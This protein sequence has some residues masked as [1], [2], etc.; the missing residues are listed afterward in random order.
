MNDRRSVAAAARRSAGLACISG[1]LAASLFAQC[2]SGSPPTVV[3]VTTAVT[4][5]A[6]SCI[7]TSTSGT[8]I[9]SGSSTVIFQAGTT[10]Y[11]LPGFTAQA[12]T[13]GTAFIASIGP[14]ITTISL[15]SGTA[16]AT[17]L[18]ELSAKE[19]ASTGPF[20]WSANGIPAGLTLSPTGVLSGTTTATGTLTATFF[21][22]DLS[23]HSSLPQVLAIAVGV[24]QTT[25][26]L[27]SSPNPSSF[28]QN[29]ILTAAVSPAN[30]TGTVT[31]ED[32]ATT[33]GNGAVALS[34][35]TAVL[36]VSTLSAGSHSL[37]AFYSGDVND[38][39]SISVPLNIAISMASPGLSLIGPS[40]FPSA[41]ALGASVFLQVGITPTGATGSVDFYDG[42]AKLG[43]APIQNGQAAFATSALTL[44]NHSLKAS[45][46]GDA[47]YYPASLSL[48]ALTVSPSVQLTDLNNG[49][50]DLFDGSPNTG[51]SFALTIR[52]AP[53]QQVTSITNN[54]SPTISGTTDSTGLFYIL[55]TWGDN[56][57]GSWVEAWYVGANQA[58]PGPPIWN[59]AAS[60]ALDFAIKQSSSV[61]AELLDTTHN[62]SYWY[63][64][65]LAPLPVPTFSAAD[66]PP[67]QF[68][69]T[70]Y[71]AQNAQ[72]Q[73]Q[74]S[75]PPYNPIC[76]NVSPTSSNTDQ[77]GIC[78]VKGTWTSSDAGS[79]TQT[80]LV[81]G[82]ASSTLTF[83]VSAT[84][85][86]LSITT[87][88]TPSPGLLGQY[89][90]L[91]LKASG[92]TG[93]YTWSG[94]QQ[95]VNGLSVSSGGLIQG[96]P[97][98]SGQFSIPV[99]VTDGG[100]GSASAT[101]T[102]VISAVDAP[103]VTTANSPPNGIVDTNYGT[104][105]FAA[106]GGSGGGYQNWTVTGSLPPGLV[107]NSAG[108]SLTGTPTMAGSYTFSVTVTD[109]AGNTSM[110]QSFTIQISPACSAV[111]EYIRLGSR[112]I[113][114]EAQGCT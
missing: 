86:P 21:A 23:G 30:A 76:S 107:W 67:T 57:A 97:G 10:V 26:S 15:P 101:F 75:N 65:Y 19:G 109:S 71:G 22:T 3:T 20:T 45:Y 17:C 52:G 29:V 43:S 54:G 41:V 66:Q 7:Q 48:P 53:G 40:P 38:A 87:S 11:L 25:T 37:T 69:L 82:S 114:I 73:L 108:D 35:N 103:Y 106:G 46:L 18:A 62:T 81:G 14:E 39:P 9:V 94:P 33:L 80:W 47:N 99:T 12:V 24:A 88:T 110:A 8:V 49:L 44:G 72:V 55:G 95:A 13:S 42:A 70:L 28:G 89:Y 4:S 78:V 105:S 27:T 90:S 2:P 56:Y 96:R 98:G 92:G 58:L 91:Q 111:K 83:V 6:T 112:V 31:F 60:P 74:G 61:T 36:A 51:D 104:Y 59:P 32:G 16:G 84:L 93:S 34:G 85:S 100:G 77:N 1:L 113:A 5:E 79:Y 68:A 102:V 50:A 64:K 63:Q